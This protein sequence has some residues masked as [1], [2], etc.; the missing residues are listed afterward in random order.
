M[1]DEKDIDLDRTKLYPFHAHSKEECFKELGCNEDLLRKGLTTAE[2]Q[3][4][5]EKFGPNQMTT[6]EKVT[7]LQRIW[8]QVA[9]VLVGILVFVAIV[10]VVRAVTATTTENIISNWIQVGLIA[11]VIW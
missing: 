1:A 8:H 7:L 4:R 3:E 9:N 11:F 2:A 5:L 6:K 10:S